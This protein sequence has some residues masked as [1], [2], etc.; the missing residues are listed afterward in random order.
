[1]KETIKSTA[2]FLLE[3]DNYIVG[4]H[5]NADGDCFGS[6]VALCTSLK[7]LGKKAKL[8]CCTKIPT[9][10]YFINQSGIE[11]Y[12]GTDGYEALKGKN[13]TYIS[14]DVASD[15]LFSDLSEFFKQNNAF[16]IDHHEK[17]TVTAQRKFVDKKASAAGEIVFAIIK[18]LE[19][20]SS[21][22]LFEKAVVNAV[23]SAISSDTGCFKYSNT[24]SK[25]HTIASKLL[26]M[27]ADSEEINYKLFDLKS[28]KQINVEKK[29]YEN[30]EFYEDGKI[31][32]IYLSDA[33]LKSIG[34]DTSDTDTVSQIGRTIEG[35][36]IAAFMRE[37]E[38]GQ[39]KVSVRSNNNAD[40][41]QLC[42]SFGIGGG[43][44]KA[45]GCTI[46]SENSDLAKQLFLS[47][48]KE[49]LE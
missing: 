29:A 13:Y 35:V 45:A 17:N 27:G 8:L 41:S 19:K 10:L 47:K 42:S 32:F 26:K 34:A 44:K 7:A 28:Q 23:F 43:H 48:A 30:I 21:T 38:K 24:T 4:I 3:N 46:F 15:H 33:C 9:R 18:E 22:A 20:K 12:E 2:E 36:Q 6:G 1:M 25:T 14:V 11:V 49:Y 5:S 16:A 31:S 39:Y 37:K 40:M